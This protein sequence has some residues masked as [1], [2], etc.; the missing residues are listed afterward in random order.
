MINVSGHLR[1]ERR[2]IGF[3][4][5]TV[6]LAV[7]CCGMQIFKTKDYSQ[8]RSLGRVDYQ[9]IY[10]YKGIG[11]YFLNGKWN[12]ITA[13]NILLFRPHEP[14]TYFYYANEHPEIYWIHFTGSD[15]EKLIE[16]YQI[17]NCYIGEHTLLK[18]LFQETIIELQLKKAYYDD[19]VLS[20][21]LHMLVMIVRSRQQLL[22]SSEN[23]FSIDRLVMQ[24]NQHYMK[25][26][27][28][29]SMAKYYSPLITEVLLVVALAIVGFTRRTVIQ[30][31]RDSKRPSF[32]RTLL[33]TTLN[34]FYFLA[35]LVQNLYTL[36]LFII[37]LY[38]ILPETMQNMRTERFLY[39]ELGLVIGVLVIVYEQIRLSLM[40]GSL[41]KEMWLPVL[42]DN[43]KVIGCIARSVSRSLPKKYY[44][45]IVRIA[46]VYNGMLYLVRRSKDE[47]VSPD[48]MD[49][50]FHNY[51]L[52]RHSIDSTVKETLGS[53]AQDKSIAPRFL[54]R[55]TFENEK[56]KHLVSLYVICLRTE[57]QLNQCKR[58]S[59]K[60]WTAKQIEENLSSGVFSE[61]FEKE[62]AYLQNTI[63]FAESFCCG[64]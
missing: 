42:N 25:D 21:F 2:V 43:G 20:S 40:Q 49:Y 29:S 26:W 47:F 55:Y 13:G 14:Q 27:T 52:F 15:C 57:E 45:P 58:R 31:I 36:H 56:V 24:L 54:I 60:L 64:N 28:V 53:L 50:P 62:F 59:G 30:R 41:K 44:H 33:R 12:S 5:E 37:L 9:L 16:K 1:N 6:P 23:D 18:T 4:D 48:T 32:K 11:H 17:H 10:V 61:Y 7:N 51:V 39:R 19:I 46:V 38:S 22:T 34:E 35:Q 3:V 63:L 8:D